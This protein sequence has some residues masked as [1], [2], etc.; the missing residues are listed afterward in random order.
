[1]THNMLQSELYGENQDTIK[2]KGPALTEDKNISI[3]HLTCRRSDLQ[4]SLVLQTHALC[5][6]KAYAI[7][8]TRE[9]Y[10]IGVVLDCIDS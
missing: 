1:M 4:F 3:L 2:L 9:L 8:N 5:P 7:K 6:L 10:E